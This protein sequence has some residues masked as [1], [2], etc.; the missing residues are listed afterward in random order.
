MMVPD[1]G[2]VTARLREGRRK[3]LGVT[4]AARSSLVPNVPTMKEQGY[5][6]DVAVWYGVFVRAETPKPA[7]GRLVAEFRAVLASPTLM[8]RWQQMEL[9]AADKVGGNFDQF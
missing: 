5:D 3:A 7:V 1:V 9:T 2:L 6:M 4:T 8:Q